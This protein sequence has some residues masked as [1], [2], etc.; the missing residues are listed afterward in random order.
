M[1]IARMHLRWSPNQ[2]RAPAFFTMCLI[3]FWGA[4]IKAFSGLIDLLLCAWELTESNLKKEHVA[5]WVVATL[6]VKF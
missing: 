4:C 6:L 1:N 3:T 2:L 5:F